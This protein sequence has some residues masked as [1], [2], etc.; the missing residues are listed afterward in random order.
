M[1]LLLNEDINSSVYYTIGTGVGG[2]ALI[3]SHLIGSQGHPE[4]GHVLLKRHPDDLDFAGVCPFHHDCLEGLV[5]GPT[6]EARVY[7]T[8]S[9]SAAG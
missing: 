5:S 2:G 4:M 8:W 1:S 3:N 9:T 7:S 6:F